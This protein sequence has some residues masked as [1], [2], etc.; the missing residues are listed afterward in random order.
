MDNQYQIIDLGSSTGTF[1]ND[2]EI[3]QFEWIDLTP[4]INLKFGNFKV[5]FSKN[6]RLNDDSGLCNHNS[7]STKDIS[8]EN[9]SYENVSLFEFCKYIFF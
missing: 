4:E 3:Q 7:S 6:H 1:V 2:V 9:S 5:K 8:I